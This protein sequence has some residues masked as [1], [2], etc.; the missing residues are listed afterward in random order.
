MVQSALN[1]YKVSKILNWVTFI[2]T[3]HNPALAWKST[4]VFYLVLVFVITFLDWVHQIYSL[5][6]WLKQ[7]ALVT[8]GV[9]ILI[10]IGRKYSDLSAQRG[11]LLAFSVGIFTI[12]PG[13]L[14]SLNPEVT[15]WSQYFSIGLAMAAGSFLG[16]IFIEFI[17]KLPK[18]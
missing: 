3:K 12:I 15:F 16:F 10:F 4:L 14:M 18:D 9:G 17:E 11:V 6:Y 7:I 2:M 1:H 13:V 8:L 5:T